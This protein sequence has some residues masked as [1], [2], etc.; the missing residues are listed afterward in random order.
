[1]MTATCPTRGFAVSIGWGC[2]RVNL[3]AGEQSETL[4]RVR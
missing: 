4:R 1:V 2:S 3:F